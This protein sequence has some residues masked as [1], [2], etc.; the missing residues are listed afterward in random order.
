MH[1]SPPVLQQT[2]VAL[3]ACRKERALQKAGF[4]AASLGFVPLTFS[5]MR[6]MQCIESKACLRLK[7]ARLS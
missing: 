1:G 7:A 5:Q 3:G 6:E 2:P 4:R